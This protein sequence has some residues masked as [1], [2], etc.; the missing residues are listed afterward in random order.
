MKRTR[1][2]NVDV[3]PRQEGQRLIEGDHQLDGGIGQ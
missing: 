1:H 3:L 2:L